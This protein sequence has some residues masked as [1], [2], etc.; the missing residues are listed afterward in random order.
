MSVSRFTNKINFFINILLFVIIVGIAYS[1]MVTDSSDGEIVRYKRNLIVSNMDI[2]V[3]DIVNYDMDA[4]ITAQYLYKD[5][6]YQLVTDDQVDL[7]NI[8]PGDVY[9]FRFDITNAHDSV[10]LS[11]IV[12]G[13]ITGDIED[14]SDLQEIIEDIYTEIGNL[15]NIG[16]FCAIW[17]A[18][19]GT[20]T[21]EPSYTPYVYKIG[22]Y[23]RIGTV[24]RRV[25]TGDTY[26]PG[27]YDTVTEDT[28]IGDVWYYDGTHWAKQ[29][30]S[31]G[32]T[33]QDVLQNGTSVLSGGIASVTTQWE[34]GTGV[35]SSQTRGCNNNAAGEA[36]TASGSDTDAHAFASSTKG[37]MTSTGANADYASAEGYKTSAQGK[38]S[39]A[40]G[41]N[42]VTN[43][44]E[45]ILTRI[46]TKKNEL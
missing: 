41:D 7:E 28:G 4:V 19:T 11:K 14:Q 29:A 38:A 17:N 27:A 40:Q 12:F 32:G 37:Y 1:W 8:A 39:H 16:R 43:N 44:N 26:V 13:E 45:Y 6:E 22:D 30:S 15:K 24:G 34:A 35:N 36:S 46:Y 21:T 33:V 20:P 31:G 5:N 42:T 25:P 2:D 10:S 18:S 3:K 9:Q 23:F